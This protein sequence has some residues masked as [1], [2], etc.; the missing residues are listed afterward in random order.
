MMESK[1]SLTF[2]FCGDYEVNALSLVKVIGSLLDMSKIV[3]ETEFPDAEFTMNV[4]AVTQGSLKFDF[5][6]VV[7]QATKTIFSAGAMSYAANLIEVLGSFFAIKKALKGNRPQ[8][9]EQRDG[10]TFITTNEGLYI[11]AHA[12]ANIYFNDNRIDRSVSRVFEAAQESGG[13]TGVTVTTDRTVE[14]TRDEFDICAKDV[15]LTCISDD[16]ITTIRSKEMLFVRQPDFTG[17]LKWKF[18][19]DQN[20]SASVLDD[21]FMER[22][23]NGKVDINS[24]T[25]I[26]ADVQVKIPKK[27]NGLPDPSRTTYDVLKVYE[28][29]SVGEGQT[30]LDI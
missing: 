3:A 13:A 1:S 12:G 14:I 5:V 20:I 30:K 29:H 27:S 10:K 17:G 8:K 24:K 19:G 9:V 11:E 6:A 16:C 26:I 7:S 25:Y 28:V 22:V 4:K 23:R 2:S 18:I 15:D 21:D